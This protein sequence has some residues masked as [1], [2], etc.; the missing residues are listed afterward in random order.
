MLL[1]T[2]T[3]SAEIHQIYFAQCITAHGIQLRGL[4]QPSQLSTQHS[5][6]CAMAKHANQLRTALKLCASTD[7][8]LD[9]CPKLPSRAAMESQAIPTHSRVAQ[10]V[11]GFHA[12]LMAA[13]ARAYDAQHSQAQRLALR[14][15]ALLVR[16]QPAVH[17]AAA[18]VGSLPAAEQCRVAP[19]Q[20]VSHSAMLC[21]VQDASRA[22]VL[23]ALLVHRRA[24]G[25]YD[26]P[27]ERSTA[28]SAHELQSAAA[29]HLA[30]VG[31]FA[32]PH[33]GAHASPVGVSGGLHVSAASPGGTTAAAAAAAKKQKKKKKK[34]KKR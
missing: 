33:K 3:S 1:S 17:K 4:N 5:A 7:E 15:T 6:S 24:E 19:G 12:A 8:C 13:R 28:A 32:S 16:A 20:P 14:A 34:K 2:T 31:A 11:P 25:K 21:A 29:G 26:P 23:K 27:S 22:A 9:A 18:A 10:A 30:G